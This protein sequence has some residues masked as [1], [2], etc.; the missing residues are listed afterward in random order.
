[1]GTSMESQTS[2]QTLESLAVYVNLSKQPLHFI[3]QMP[4]RLSMF[5]YQQRYDNIKMI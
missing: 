4:C 1:M 5:H 3:F 2:V